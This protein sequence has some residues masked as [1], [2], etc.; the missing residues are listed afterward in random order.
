V[1]DVMPAISDIHV[2]SLSYM[3]NG[4]IQIR[5]PNDNV[6]LLM[7]PLLEPGI[8]CVERNAENWQVG[9][10]SSATTGAATAGGGGTTN[11][12]GD[13]ET[14]DDNGRTMMED[15]RT[16]ADN[17][18]RAEVL[19]DEK[20]KAR[21]AR[22]KKSALSY[23]TRHRTTN[24]RQQQQQQQDFDDYQSSSSPDDNYEQSI[25]K[26]LS[27]E[28]GYYNPD[29]EWQEE[30]LQSKSPRSVRRTSHHLNTTQRQAKRS[31]RRRT[32]KGSERQRRRKGQFPE[33]NYV[34]TVDQDLYKRVLKEMSDSRRPCGLYYCCHEASGET[35]HVDIGVAIG[36]LSIVLTLMAIATSY[37]PW[38]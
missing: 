5:V 22:R 21:D 15:W 14:N 35:K 30:E 28:D 24:R 20:R 38:S 6:K 36:L 19:E 9:S 32:R 1:G 18:E 37:W 27:M 33:L 29:E 16:T 17:I 26:S 8:M 7:D 31:H 12:V 34:L 3:H 11:G 23:S 2:S 4:R 25:L 10:S 13:Y